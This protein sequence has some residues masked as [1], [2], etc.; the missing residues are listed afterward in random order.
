LELEE[1]I[2][3]KTSSCDVSTRLG[4]GS[5]IVVRNN[6]LVTVSHNFD[7]SEYGLSARFKVLAKQ[8]SEWSSDPARRDQVAA[9]VA[10]Y[11]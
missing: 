11:V 5:A 7:L 1:C 10:A 3:R 6:I 4:R 2:H 9:E 8:W